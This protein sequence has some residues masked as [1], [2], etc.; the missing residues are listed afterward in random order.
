[1]QPANLEDFTAEAMDEGFDEIITR[2][3]AP[4]LQLDSHTHPFDL[5]VHVARGSLVLTVGDTSRPYQAR[6]PAC[7]TLRL[8]G[9]H[10]LGRPGEL[11]RMERPCMK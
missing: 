1:M 10:I 5:R 7:R 2:E 6:H 4:N 8:P 9:R 3:W 11:N